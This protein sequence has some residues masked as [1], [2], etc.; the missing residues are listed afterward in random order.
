MFYVILLELSIGE[1]FYIQFLP[2]CTYILFIVNIFLKCI[3]FY[4]FLVK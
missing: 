1:Q 4:L 3:G 2:A